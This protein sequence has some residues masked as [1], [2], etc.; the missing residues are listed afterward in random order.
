M[1]ESEWKATVLIPGFPGKANMTFLGWSSAVLL[2]NEEQICLFDTGGHGARIVLLDALRAVGIR[3]EQVRTVFLSHLHFDHCANA[4][5]F[6]QATF[7]TS[8]E[9]WEYAER[10]DSPLVLSAML[11]FL[12]GAK[13]RFAADGEECFPGLRTLIVPGHTPG[14]LAAALRQE[15]RTWIIAGDAVKNRA[16]LRSGRV[17]IT[18][19]AEQSARSIERIRTMADRVLPGHDCWLTVKGEKVLPE[20]GNDVVIT[21]PEGITGNGRRTVTLHLDDEDD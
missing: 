21:F 9:E 20:G 3:P 12:R 10:T 1:S 16:E 17:G 19:E 18:L 7:V 8:R 11:P 4:D 13:R 2:R 6:P 5:L 14:C 15:G